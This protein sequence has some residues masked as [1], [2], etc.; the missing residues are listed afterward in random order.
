MAL[1]KKHQYASILISFGLLA[2]TGPGGVTVVCD[3][4]SYI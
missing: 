4:N 3:S 1:V 2:T